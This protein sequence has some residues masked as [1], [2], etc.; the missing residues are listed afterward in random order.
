MGRYRAG[1]L[2]MRRIE[3]FLFVGLGVL[4][5]GVLR[6]ETMG[7]G[8]AVER[9]V[10]KTPEVG[11]AQASVSAAERQAAGTKALR[12]PSLRAE[13]NVL[14]W[15][16]PLLVNFGPMTMPG[17][18]PAAP[19]VVRDQ[20][21][22]ALSLTIAQP[23]SGLFALS[24]QVAIDSIGVA[25]A[26][27]E[28]AQAKLN[29]A[30]R[31]ASAYLAVLLAQAEAEVAEKAVAQI[32]AQLERAQR[33]E[34]AG[35]LNKVD[36]LRLISARD[37]A[38][39]DLVNAQTNVEVAR[40]QLGL[41]INVAPEAVPDV[42][43]NLPDPPRPL[44]ATDA[45][46]AKA[47]ANTRPE[48]RLAAAQVEQAEA[49][50][51][52]AKSDWLPNVNAVGT[53]Q[54]VRGQGPFQPRDAW[55]VGATMTWDIWSWGSTYQGVKAADAR[56][57]AA[58]RSAEAVQNQ[59]LVEARERLLEA[60][61][62]YATLEPARTALEAATEAHRI[63]SLRYQEGVATT[64]DILAA[65]TDLSRARSGYAQA[66]YR[67]YQAQVALARATGALPAAALR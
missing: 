30:Q 27:A 8:E 52:V 65:E 5:S 7:F 21:T 60:R 4:P 24:R 3:I 9:A 13:G 41:A 12:Y 39:L 34:A 31:A 1:R 22:A 59:V 44:V 64:T 6:A 20:Y 48:M 42:V 16:E 57:L 25:A 62:A 50:R 36:V 14:R 2:P 53:F 66:R 40:A 33:Q 47:A 35:V 61:A 54:H 10:E 18:P 26:Q 32:D 45:D 55:F 49:A 67:Y 11:A 23:I 37:A 43:D 29:V 58:Q 17:T 63:Q 38:K 15:N 56:A 19:L 28:T 46:V 51:G